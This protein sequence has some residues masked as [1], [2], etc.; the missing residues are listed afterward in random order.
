LRTPED[1]HAEIKKQIELSMLSGGT[2][3]V[4][5]AVSRSGIKDS[6]TTTIVDRLLALGKMLRKKIAG[7]PRLSEADVTACLARELDLLLSGQSLDDRINPLLSM[8]GI[9]IHKDTP[10]KILH[11]VLLGIVKYFWGQTA[12]ILEK[13]Q[14]IRVFQTRLASINQ[15]GLNALTIHADNIIRYKGALVGKHF[16]GLAQVMPYLIYDLVPEKVL[17]GWSLIGKLVVLLW[18]ASIEDTEAYLVSTS[19]LFAFGSIVTVMH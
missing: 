7:Q 1:T 2:E 4:K 15:E 6:A 10:T 8:P 5:N 11:T 16:K 12:Y 19:C 14:L 9:N 3:K 17:Q 18:H 13:D